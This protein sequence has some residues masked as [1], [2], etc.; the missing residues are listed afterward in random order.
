M[1]VRLSYDGGMTWPVAKQLHTGPS[2]YSCLTV[3]PDMTIGCFYE[4]GDQDRYEKLTF[5]RFNLEWLT[6][7]KDSVSL[8]RSKKKTCERS[9]P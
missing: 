4:R 9:V 7:G 8:D 5:A 1:T 3:L 2:A 6:D